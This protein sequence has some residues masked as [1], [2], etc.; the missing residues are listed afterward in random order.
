MSISIQLLGSPRV[1]VDGEDQGR[2]RGAKT[3]ALLALLAR[4]EG[5]IPRTRIAELLFSEADDPLGALRWTA[6]QL[7]RLLN[8]SDTVVGDP[9]V[10]SLP[11]DATVDTD[12][13]IGGRWEDALDV[14]GLGRPLLEGIEPRAGASFELWLSGE[15]RHLDGAA[16]AMLHEAASAL[17]ARDEADRAV[18]V[19]NRLVGLNPYDENA[20]VMLVQALVAVGDHDAADERVRIC[21]NLFLEELDVEP[22]PALAEA[23]RRRA[24]RVRASPIMLQAQLEA[25]Q[26]AMSAGVVDAGLETLRGVAEGASALK[27]D[28]LTLQAL[29]ALGVALVH[30]TRGTDEEAVTVLH[31]ARDLADAIGED[32]IGGSACRELGYVELL[33][34]RY[35]RAN[36][37]LESG[38]ERA[39]GND[40]ELGWIEL[41]SGSCL[42]DTAHYTQ[43]EQ[44]LRRAVELTARV[45]DTEGEAFA[46]THLCRLHVLRDELDEARVAGRR[47]LE[48]TDAAAWTSF[49]PYPETWAAL[50]EFRHGRVDESH[51]LFEH[52]W[53][54]ACQIGDVCW[55]TLSLRGLGLIS[56]ERECPAEAIDQLSQAPAYCRRLPDAYRWAEA[57]ALEALV[58]VAIDAEDDRASAWLAQLDTIASRHGFREFQARAHLH[59]ADLGEDDAWKLGALIAAE[60]DNPLLARDVAVREP[61][62]SASQGRS[63]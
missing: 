1:E 31:R 9:M 10:L 15:R 50:A 43:G 45:G 42:S 46:T 36:T 16:S 56:A 25:G 35:D 7:R 20:H 33:R 3:W 44:A 5:A 32:S 37:W 12:V 22:S 55:Q 13:I 24:T 4:S 59:R 39:A 34:G 18:A 58:G 63:R 48:L 57:Y 23:A 38:R 8:S 26:A 30:T 51:Q 28:P 54:M 21:T 62:T 29:F 47:A 60:I 53:A 19:A 52:A 2:P 11:A 49:R 41:V 17:L 27:D 6:S 14:S 40:T 61:A